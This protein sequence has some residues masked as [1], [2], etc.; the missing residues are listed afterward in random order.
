MRCAIAC[1]LLHRQAVRE[2]ASLEARGLV[3]RIMAFMA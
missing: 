3:R 2:V 1:I